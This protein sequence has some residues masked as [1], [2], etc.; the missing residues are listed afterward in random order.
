VLAA[1]VERRLVHASGAVV[2]L[3]WAGG[4]VDWR[5][6]QA[7]FGG[8]LL[9]VAAMEA[10]RLSGRLDLAIYDRLTR[11]YE[12]DNVAGY[13]LYML[14][15][16]L[17]AFAFSP[18]VAAP[19]MLMLALGDPVSGLLGSGSLRSVKQTWVLLVMFGVCTL[20]AAPFVPAVAA[21]LGGAAATLADGVK[22][23][24][25]GYVVDDNLTIPPA[26]A[27][28]ITAGLALATLP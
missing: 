9:V 17:V 22:P 3:A 8:G 11:E 5:V 2:P 16:A 19:S 20:L 18:T 25:A 27:V 7:V 15:M 24:V 14:S 23:V 10:G 12:Q 1:E 6:V 13:A 21:V 28:A 26:A 4:L